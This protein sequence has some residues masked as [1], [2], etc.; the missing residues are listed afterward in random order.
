MFRP[1]DYQSTQKI[2]KQPSACLVHF[3]CL[4]LTRGRI[5]G[6]IGFM[7]KKKIFKKIKWKGPPSLFRGTF[8][9]V[10][11]LSKLTVFFLLFYSK[12]T[13]LSRGYFLSNFIIF[14]SKNLLFLSEFTFFNT[15]L[16]LLVTQNLPPF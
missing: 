7:V 5:D 15:F 12:F 16:R 14:F 11:F 4:P 10:A 3:S 6:R 2:P 8:F 9:K 1:K 13:F